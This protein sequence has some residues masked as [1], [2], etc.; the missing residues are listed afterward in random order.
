MSIAAWIGMTA[1]YENVVLPDVMGYGSGGGVGP[2]SKGF[3]IQGWS[4]IPRCRASRESGDFRDATGQQ[5][6]DYF[7]AQR[8]AHSCWPK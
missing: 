8:R 5:G 7:V 1:S 2:V 4:Q 6:P 3:T